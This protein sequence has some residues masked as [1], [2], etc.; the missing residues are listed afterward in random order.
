MA[1]PVSMA[2]KRD[3]ASFVSAIRN[4]TATV[5]VKPVTKAYAPQ[6]LKANAG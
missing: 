1:T 3:M 5:A 6:G 2:T 4:T